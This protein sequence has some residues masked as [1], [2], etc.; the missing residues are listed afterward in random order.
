MEPVDYQIQFSGTASRDDFQ[1]ELNG[2]FASGVRRASIPIEVVSDQ[3]IEGEETLVFHLVSGDGVFHPSGENRG[4]LTLVD[5]LDF[6]A[7]LKIYFGELVPFD[8]DGDGDGASELEEYLL[9]SDPRS[10]QSKKPLKIVWD[11]EQVFLIVEDLPQR[12]DAMIEAQVSLDLRNWQTI[13]FTREDDG[14]R[15]PWDAAKGFV[16]LVFRLDQ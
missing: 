10:K 12:N 8:R 6:E 4:A 14:L 16:R 11:K 3:I 15:I 13:S 7:W 1:G 2:V 5:H 9:G